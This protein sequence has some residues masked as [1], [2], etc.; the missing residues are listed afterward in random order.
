MRSN[1]NSRFHQVDSEDLTIAVN[2]WWQSDMMSGMP[3]HMDAYYLRR[4]LKRCAL[5]HIS[6]GCAFIYLEIRNMLT[7]LPFPCLLA[8]ES[9][10][11]G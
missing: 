7:F 2:F 1:S 6:F 9:K 3:E 11:Q 4:L 8:M 5:V 10:L